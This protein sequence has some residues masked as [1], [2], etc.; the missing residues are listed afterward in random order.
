MTTKS[1]PTLSKIGYTPQTA[2]G[3]PD[4]TV[5]RSQHKPEAEHGKGEIRTK[6]STYFTKAPS[7][8]QDPTAVLYNGDRLWARVVL[9][10]ETAGPV[11]VGDQSS[12][13]PVLSGRGQLLATGEPTPFVI[14]KG[15]K[16]FIAATAV[17]RVKVVIEPVPWLEQI[18]GL[19]GSFVDRVVGLATRKAVR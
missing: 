5:A 9:T 11:A 2:I 1:G 4:R 19:L 13:V 6:V 10:L 14:A 18:T 16:L 17:N 3:G 8:G 12:I 15:T 7:I